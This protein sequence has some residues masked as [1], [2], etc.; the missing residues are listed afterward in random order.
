[1]ITFV[2][3]ADVEACARVLDYRRL[4]K[5]RCEAYQ[6]WRALMGRGKILPDGTEGPPTKGWRNHPATK[7][8]EG[9][10]CFLAMYCNAMIDEWVARGYRN[11]M[12]K[13]P[14]CSCARPPPW[15]GWPP[16]H[17]SHQA[18]LNRK[19]PS[20]YT[21]PETEYANWGYVWP[22]KVQFQ[23]K[24]KDPRPEAVCEP[25]KHTLQKTSYHRDKSEPLQ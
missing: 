19:L 21:F 16:I 25:L 22:T 5:Q 20:H 11:F 15:W 3:F 18:S 17:L 6:I 4:G 2:P 1:M 23:N 14:H 13:L 8:W 24:I 9:H 12:N 10:T 7:M